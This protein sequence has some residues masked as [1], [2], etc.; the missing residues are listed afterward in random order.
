MS[1]VAIDRNE[2]ARLK[3]AVRLP[4]L[5]GESLSLQRTGRY[6]VAKCPFHGERTPSF[7]VYDDHYHCFGC[8]A[9]GDVIRWLI[10]GRKLSCRE[11]FQYLRGAA[12]HT[13]QHH[14]T[15]L[16]PLPGKIAPAASTLA[17]ARRV[18]AEGVGVHG[19]LAATYL[20]SRGLRLPNPI[21]N[22]DDYRYGWDPFSLR[23]HPHCQRGPRELPGG[24]C[25][26]PALLAALVEPVTGDF[27]GVHRTFLLDDG[28]GKAPPLRIADVT[29][30]SKAILG[31]WGVVKLVQDDRVGHALALAE[32]LENAITIAQQASY[33]TIW[34]AGRADGIRS[35]PL[36][37]GIEALSIF[38]DGD[39][40]GRSAAA[41]CAK[42]WTRDGREVIL[43][44]PPARYDWNSA[45]I[46]G[47][48]RAA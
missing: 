15:S 25:S 46:A 3:E 27:V 8:G 42:R 35:F 7:I 9:H 6:W 14:L 22:D 2:I 37:F 24:P 43:H 31:T 19:T 23:F 10:D 13:P 33:T 29:L 18:W 47:L 36:L 39:Q 44:S 20:A 26:A 30:P 17:A 28:S 40:A 38:V 5:I 41:S 12:G 34:A 48:G 4:S 16:A 32:G 21:V 11:A 1:A 45:L